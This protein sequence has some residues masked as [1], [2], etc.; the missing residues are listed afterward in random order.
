MNEKCKQQPN[1]K[2]NEKAEK[3]FLLRSPAVQFNE[4]QFENRGLLW[5]YNFSEFNKNVFFVHDHF[6]N[7]SQLI[8]FF[9]FE[10]R[11][12]SL[13][14]LALL[15]LLLLLLLFLIFFWWFFP[16][17]CLFHSDWVG[18]M[19]TLQISQCEDMMRVCV[20]RDD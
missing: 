3:K 5:V 18:W 14:L 2:R 11:Q 13:T 10:F 19:T 17:M 9:F 1:S 7:H 6:F 16:L 15:W 8:N 4:D 20:K 12:T